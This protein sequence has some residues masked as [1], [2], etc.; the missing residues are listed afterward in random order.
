MDIFRSRLLFRL[1]CRHTSTW[2]LHFFDDIL[3][4][5]FWECHLGRR[6]DDFRG[7]GLASLLN[8]AG[9]AHQW[10]YVFETFNQLNLWATWH[11]IVYFSQEPHQPQWE[12]AGATSLPL[13]RLWKTLNPALTE[14]LLIHN[15][16]R[17]WSQS[18]IPLGFVMFRLKLVKGLVS[19]F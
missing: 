1:A 7:W 8:M 10:K 14:K 12:K 5:T 4:P 3:S 17:T 18:I 11:W 6:D 15:S 16:N 9:V 19:R 13:P 2:T